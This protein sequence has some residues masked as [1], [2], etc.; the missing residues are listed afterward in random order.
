MPTPAGGPPRARGILGAALLLAAF[1]LAAWPIHM[2]FFF[3]P[4]AGLLVL[5]EPR[6][7][8]EF[9]WIAVSLLWAVAWLPRPSP[10]HL[11]AVKAGVVM[12]TGALVALRLSR[13][14]LAPGAATLAAVGLAV[15]GTLLWSVGLGLGWDAMHA[16][17]LREGW[18]TYRT[19]VVQAAGASP[20]LAESLKA[21]I[22]PA[23]TLFP[24]LAALMGLAGVRLAWGWHRRI[25][26][27][28]LQPAPAGLA[29]FRFNDHLVWG[30]AGA[31][32]LVLFVAAGPAAALGQNLLLVFGA[33]Y[34]GRGLAVTATLGAGL[35][36]FVAALLAASAL[37]LFP[38]AATGLFVLGVADTW[39]DFRRR[40]APPL[41]GGQD[42]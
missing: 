31:L 3:L 9:A 17:A 42:R 2:G 16:A 12:A 23:A 32:A 20:V 22:G 24:G 27:V 4:L 38:F 1:L 13:P 37:L 33:L 41:P 10:M 28:P 7:I 34:A 30:L 25:A 14:A 40:L 19:L 26:R 11:Q 29:E 18:S 15:L 5:A 6:S 36:R 35:P 21:G 8:R 39:V